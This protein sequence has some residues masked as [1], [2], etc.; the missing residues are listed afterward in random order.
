MQFQTTGDSLGGQKLS[1]WL[2]FFVQKLIMPPLCT[3]GGM[4]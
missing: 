4:V 2:N 3:R 1:Y